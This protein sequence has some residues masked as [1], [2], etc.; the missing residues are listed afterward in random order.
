MTLVLVEGPSDARAV[1]TL[2]R[3]RGTDL[4][5]AGVRIEAM[6]GITNL[7]RWLVEHGRA[8]DKVLVL[9]DAGEAAYVLR[10]VE[11]IG[12]AVQLYVCDADLEDELIRGLGVPAALAVVEKAGDLEL[13][14]TLTRQPFHRNRPAEAV[15]RRFMGTTSGRKSR[16][17]GLLAE[18]AVELDCVPPPLD[19]LL[20]AATG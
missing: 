11:R 12:V 19:A 1:E 4:A 6:G 7:G 9:Y 13:W 14:E 15:L 3:Q 2:A 16:Y 18:A 10:T 20:S 17:A 8:A 5:A